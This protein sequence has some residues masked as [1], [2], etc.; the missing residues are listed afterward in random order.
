MGFVGQALPAAFLLLQESLET[1]NADAAARASAVID[2]WTRNS[3]TPEGV[4]RTSC[5]IHP[6]G[7]YTWRDYHTFLRVASDGADGVLSAWNVMH[8]Q[9][10]ERPE[11]LS[12]CRRYGDWLVSAQNADGS[13]S[14]EYSFVGTALE[15]SKDT[16]DHPIRFLCD[17]FR[18]TGDIRY[19]AAV[20]RA[21]EFCLHS[22]HDAYAYVGG[23]PDDPRWLAAATQAAQYS[24]TWVYCW[25]IP[26]PEGDPKAVF[27][28]HRPIYGLSLIATGHSGCD[29]YMASAPFL[30]YWL[31]LLT[32][33]SHFR[34]MA[35]LLLY[36]TKQLLDWD[37]TLGCACGMSL[38][39]S[40]LTRLRNCR[41]Q[42][43]CG[44]MPSSPRHA[45]SRNSRLFLD[46]SCPF[47]HNYVL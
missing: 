1:K 19:R 37:N 23:T 11:W 26:V 14:R 18:A 9:G 12:F 45:V 28:R 15:R 40:T 8:K 3:L 39:A 35:R 31:F 21:G 36:D 29:T 43:A 24:E 2:L 7:T 25:D 30:F 41:N 4:P 20:L 27:P 34:E 42:S 32:G 46:F 17:L 44:G 38:A 10:L 13:Y 16:T 5:D 6:D 22:V 47:G 33:D